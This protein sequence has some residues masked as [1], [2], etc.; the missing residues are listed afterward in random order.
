MNTRAVNLFVDVENVN[1]SAVERVP[2]EEQYIPLAPWAGFSK[3]PLFNL[4]AKLLFHEERR[5]YGY[6]YD[7]Q[8]HADLRE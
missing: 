7:N 1:V 3:V 4:F 5:I 6:T 2:L 8:G